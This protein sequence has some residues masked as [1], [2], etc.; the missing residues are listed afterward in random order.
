M[1]GNAWEWTR[2]LWGKYP[3]PQDEK[4]RV[5]RE[6]TNAPRDAGRVL[7]GGSFGSGRWG[8][9]CSVRLRF[10]PVGWSWV[11]GFRVVVSPFATEQ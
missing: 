1:S 5:E 7:R 8:V 9:R 4:E 3:Y 2:S 11:V 10:Y 6:N